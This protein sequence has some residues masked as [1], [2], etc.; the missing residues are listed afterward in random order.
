MY[1]IESKKLNKYHDYS[2]KKCWQ[3]A[4]KIVDFDTES[5]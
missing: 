5:D 2:Y 3:I 4:L 1:Y